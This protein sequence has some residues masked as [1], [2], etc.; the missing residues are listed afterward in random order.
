MKKF[1]RTA[2]ICSYRLNIY[3]TENSL[4]PYSTYSKEYCM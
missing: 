3:A 2:K 1:T 4:H